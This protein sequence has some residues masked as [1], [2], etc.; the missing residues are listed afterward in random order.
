MQRSSLSIGVMVGL[1]LAGM[2]LLFLSFSMGGQ[3]Y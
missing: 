3:I 2:I 1:E